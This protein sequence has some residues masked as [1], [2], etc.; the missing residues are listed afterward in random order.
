MINFR[1][2]D[3]FFRSI[4]FIKG[5]ESQGVKS[6]LSLICDLICSYWRFK[7]PRVSRGAGGTYPESFNP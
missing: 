7:P 1:L 2:L 6:A 5:Y 3:Y 4:C